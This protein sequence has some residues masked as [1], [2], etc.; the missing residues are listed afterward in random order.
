MF[1]KRIALCIS[2]PLSVLYEKSLDTMNCPNEW[3][4]ALIIA[5]F[6]KGV[7]FSGKLPS[8]QSNVHLV[9]KYGVAYYGTY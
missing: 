5:I 7:V 2:G 3:L 1:L 8:H 9:Q 4:K 6:K